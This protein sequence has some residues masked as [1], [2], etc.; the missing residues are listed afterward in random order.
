MIAA[1]VLALLLLVPLLIVALAAFAVAALWMGL[2]S[3]VGR[4][5]GDGRRNV[6]L[7]RPPQP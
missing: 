4:L 6:R 2:R 3:L 5:R 7:V 1:A